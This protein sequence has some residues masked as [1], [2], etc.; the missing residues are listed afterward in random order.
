[1]I[2]ASLAVIFGLV[3][4]NYTTDTWQSILLNLSTEL[5]G[6]VVV[7]FLVNYFLIGDD[8]DLSERVQRLVNR[9]ELSDRPSA[10]LFFQKPP[11]IDSYVQSAEQIDLCGVS[12]T[13]TINKQFST[14]RERLQ[15]GCNVRLIVIDPANSQAVE[16]SGLRSEARD[17]DYFHRKLAATFE[18]IQ[19]LHKS[20][21]EYKTHAPETTGKLAIRLLPYAPSFGLKAFDTH[22]P[23]G[24]VF[25]EAYPHK[26]ASKVPHFELTQQ[27]DGAW[28]QYFVDQFAKMWR[29]STPWKPGTLFP[30][31]NTIYAQYVKRRDSATNFFTRKIPDLESRLNEATSIAITGMTLMRTSISLW[32]TFKQR[33]EADAHLRFLIIDPDDQ[34]VDVAANRFDKFQDP[35]KLKQ[36]IKQALGNFETLIT[37]KKTNNVPQIRLFP[38]VPPYG[39]WLIDA[40]TPT[41]EIWVEVYSF[42]DGPDPTFHLIAER[43]GE[44]FDFFQR[45]VEIMWAVSHPWELNKLDSS[46]TGP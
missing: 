44:W 23:Q 5:L 15:E 8:W 10:T 41:A 9:L 25:V 36:E 31:A 4:I 6:V 43:D 42:R 18:D 40:D 19:Y 39:I 45:Q 46:S 1:M 37:Q 7:F 21:E 17:T 2:I 20:W 30:S 14:L 22:Q 33:L 26:T 34:A 29:D 27:R 13:S 38:G 28:Y 11:T 3:G 12:L 35:E 24:M 16:M 32:P